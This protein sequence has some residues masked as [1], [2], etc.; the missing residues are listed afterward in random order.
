MA[1]RVVDAVM[2]A[3]VFNRRLDRRYPATLSAPTITGLL[4]GDLGWHG[5]VVSDDLRMGAIEQHYGLDEAAVLALAAGVDVLLIADDRLPDGR[6]AAHVAL[7]AI[8]HALSEGS[9]R[10]ASRP[11]SREWPR[12]RPAARIRSALKRCALPIAGHTNS[13][14]SAQDLAE[15]IPVVEHP[16]LE[17]V[18]HAKTTDTGCW[19]PRRRSPALSPAASAIPASRNRANSARS[20]STS[21]A[22]SPRARATAS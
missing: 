22:Q 19:P 4:R 8:R 7:T 16:L 10:P 14:T 13:C 20:S 3:H 2:T 1:E 12:S 15:M 18:G 5:V 11:P 21:R 6:S 9:S 17:E